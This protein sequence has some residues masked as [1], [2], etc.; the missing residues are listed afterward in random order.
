MTAI[1]PEDMKKES[2]SKLPLRRFGHP[3]EAANSIL[4]VASSDASYMTASTMLVDGGFLA[5]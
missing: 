1:Y 4:F 5:M 3:E 2:Q